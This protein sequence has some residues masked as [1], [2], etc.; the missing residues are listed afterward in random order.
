MLRGQAPPLRNRQRIPGCERTEHGGKSGL[1]TAV[2]GIDDREAREL[3][4]GACCNRVERADVPEQTN[5]NDQPETSVPKAD[6]LDPKVGRGGAS[7]GIL[8]QPACANEVLARRMAE[9]CTV[10]YYVPLLLVRSQGT[11]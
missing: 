11:Q 5:P 6:E 10:G 2:F 8:E 7:D 4:R 3:Y 9:L 1:A